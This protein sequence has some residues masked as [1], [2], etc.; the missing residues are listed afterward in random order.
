MLSF[1]TL[2]LLAAQGL[3]VPLDERGLVGSLLKGPSVEIHDGTVV[4]SSLLGVESFKGIPYAQPPVGDL[5]LKQPQPINSSLGTI[6]ASTLLPKAC[7]QFYAQVHSDKLVSDVLGTVL[8]TPLL[9]KVTEQD[10]DCL[11]VNVQRPSGV[12]SSSKLPVLFWIYGGGYNFGATQL[13]DGSSIVK[14]SKMNGEPII[15]VAVNYR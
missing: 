8:N 10:E 13:Y 14:R 9:Q 4:G 7:P 3:A 11:T 12:D 1:F 2:C 6:N 5:R 15:F